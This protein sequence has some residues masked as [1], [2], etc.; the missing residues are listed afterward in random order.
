MVEKWSSG[1]RVPNDMVK[2][3]SKNGPREAVDHFIPFFD[4]FMT[5]VREI[6]NP[7]GAAAEGR[8]PLWVAAEG[9]HPHFCGRMVIK[10]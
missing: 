3:W 10:L 2:K 5:I 4:H 1:T 9:R 6:G 7:K 8:R